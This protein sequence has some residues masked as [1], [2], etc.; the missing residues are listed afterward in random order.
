M[1]IFGP[2]MR[3]K[4]VSSIFEVIIISLPFLYSTDHLSLCIAN[5]PASI[6]TPRNNTGRPQINT[7]Y[8]RINRRRS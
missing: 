1:A 5:R 8:W 6:V 3:E 7:Q 2:L 4:V